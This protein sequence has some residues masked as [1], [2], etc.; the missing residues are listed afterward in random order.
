MKK[1]HVFYLLIISIFLVS[2]VKD[3]ITNDI[4]AQSTYSKKIDQLESLSENELVNIPYKEGYVTIVTYGEDTLAVAS[5]ENETMFLQKGIVL[6]EGS[7]STKLEQNTSNTRSIKSTNVTKA[8]DIDEDAVDTY[9][10]TYEDAKSFSGE[11]NLSNNFYAVMF[12]DTKNADYDYNDLIIHTKYL[13]HYDPYPTEVLDVYVQGIALGSSKTIKLG[14][15]TQTGKKYVSQ[16]VRE[17]LFS[18]ENL[19]DQTQQVRPYF[20][21]T[22]KVY[23]DSLCHFKMGN[24]VRCSVTDKSTDYVVW[25]IEA[26]NPQ[27]NEID[28]FIAPTSIKMAD[29]TDRANMFSSIGRSYGV[30][31]R[32]TLTIYPCEKVSIDKPFPNFFKWIDGEIDGSFDSVALKKSDDSNVNQYYINSWKIWDYDKSDFN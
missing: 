12:E 16:N 17:D 3:T 14:F 13:F 32:S 29:I 6:P 30:V 22:E 26:I 18:H 25:F 31:R 27:T 9:K 4:D 10:V 5:R 11:E 20:I 28:T 2:C 15:Y 19:Y 21:N 8:D 24:K 23:E 1:L 7:Y